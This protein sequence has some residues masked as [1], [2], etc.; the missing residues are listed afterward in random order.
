M[1]GMQKD[2]TMKESWDE[3]AGISLVEAS[4]SHIEYFTISSF[5]ELILEAQNESVKAV[6]SKLCI[7]YGINKI[8]ASPGSLFEK[9]YINGE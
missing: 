4:N 9:N 5:V 6:L 3:Y 8:L 7:L 2:M 1:E